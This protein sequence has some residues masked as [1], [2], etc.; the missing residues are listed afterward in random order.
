ML[1]SQAVI[2]S[3]QSRC[4]SLL[5]A[6]TQLNV[7]F[8]EQ[9]P[10]RAISVTSLCTKWGALS[11]AVTLPPTR[12]WPS[13]QVPLTQGSGSSGTVHKHQTQCTKEMLL[14]LRA[15]TSSLGWRPQGGRQVLDSPAVRV[16]GVGM[17]AV[18]L[19]ADNGIDPVCELS[20]RREGVWVQS[21]PAA[22]ADEGVDALDKPVTD[23]GSSRVPL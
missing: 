2:N 7:G 10:K 8:G 6:E 22:S 21:R 19:P 15:A 5:R 11:P 18:I 17:G 16:S 12:Q 13:P 3:W 1:L 9:K 4:L 14:L 23:Q 20:H